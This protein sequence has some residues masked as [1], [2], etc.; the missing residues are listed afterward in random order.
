[1]NAYLN[2]VNVNLALGVRK[3]ALTFFG[4]TKSLDLTKFEVFRLLASIIPNSS[5]SQL[6]LQTLLMALLFLIEGLSLTL[7]IFVDIN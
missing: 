7:P 2:W 4:Y 5:N 3:S 6:L 1:M